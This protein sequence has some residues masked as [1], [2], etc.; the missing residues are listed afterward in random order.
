ME[1]HEE[2]LNLTILTTKKL[3]NEVQQILGHP[4]FDRSCK[5]LK[6]SSIIS[7]DLSR[8]SIKTACACFILSDKYN[9]NPIV[10]DSANVMRTLSIKNSCPNIRTYAQIMTSKQKKN[11]RHINI[12]GLIGIKKMKMKMITLNCFY[13]GTS[14][15][16]TN[17][18]Q[19][20]GDLEKQDSNKKWEYEYF[21]G[22]TQT[23]FTVVLP[24]VFNNKTFTETAEIIF[25]HLSIIL[26]AIV[27]KDQKTGKKNCVLNPSDSYFVKT[28]DIAYVITNS[29]E[30]ARKISN[31]TF[32]DTTQSDDLIEKEIILTKTLTFSQFK[33]NYI[34]PLLLS[35]K[36]TILNKNKIS[37]KNYNNNDVEL[38]YLTSIKKENES[39]QELINKSEDDLSGSIDL[40]EEIFLEKEEKEKAKESETGS[41]FGSNSDSGSRS[42]S[43]SGSGSGSRSGS[44]LESESDLQ[45]NSEME[46]EYLNEDENQLLEEENSLHDLLNLY[47]RK[48]NIIR[49]EKI[50]GQLSFDAKSISCKPRKDIEKN[51]GNYLFDNNKIEN[52]FKKFRKLQEKIMHGNENEKNDDNEHVQNKSEKSDFSSTDTNEY[53]KKNSILK[54]MKAL[55]IKSCENLKNHLILIGELEDLKYFL[56]SYRKKELILY[57]QNQKIKNL[58]LKNFRPKKIVYA[59]KTPLTKKQYLYFNKTY[60][61]LYNVYFFYS[62]P[63]YLEN[64]KFLNFENAKHI[65][66]LPNRYTEIFQKDSSSFKHEFYRDSDLLFLTR[67]LLQFKKCPTLTVEII[68]PTNLKLLKPQKKAPHRENYQQ[69]LRQS[70]DQQEESQKEQHTEF[71][72][73]FSN[74][75]SNHIYASGQIFTEQFFDALFMHIYFKPD[76]FHI[77]KKLTNSI[78]SL[79]VNSLNRSQLFRKKI[80]KQFYNKRFDYLFNHLLEKEHNLVIGLL[81]SPNVKKLGNTSP[82]IYTN[83]EP[84]TIILKGDYAFI[85]GTIH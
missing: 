21:E 32:S 67:N 45:S 34:D 33:K 65:L 41:D 75:R 71:S 30:K 62:S 52:E 43:R 46:Q 18:V 5:L 2:S 68:H 84:Y 56:I 12:D 85:L 77:I 1:N 10:H 50:K 82:Y 24:H 28:G 20:F 47:D 27:V 3:S 49:I 76:L 72:Q 79:Q 63:Y 22:L 81:R 16:I 39:T 80:S 38:H 83:P 6:G 54:K 29:L 64:W 78:H 74:F 51:N 60:C 23:I 44:E 69:V 70:N 8:I 9:L 66:L 55:K 13:P 53:I 4:F 73:F 17:L 40:N 7:S 14:T 57:L 35:N 31:F 15:L 37:K 36:Y 58:N 42:R 48:R 25:S 26:F 61:G 11:L 59:T 19:E